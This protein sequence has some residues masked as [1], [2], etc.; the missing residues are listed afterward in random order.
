[1]WLLYLCRL[2]AMRWSVEEYFKLHSTEYKKPLK[3]SHW[4][5][6]KRLKS[7]FEWP[8]AA[9]LS[10]ESDMEVTAGKTLKHLTK[11]MDRLRGIGRGYDEGMESRTVMVPANGMLFKLRQELQ[12]DGALV[13]GLLFLAYLDIGGEHIFYILD[14]YVLRTFFI[15]TVHFPFT[16]K[17]FCAFRKG[18]RHFDWLA[19]LREHIEVEEI[20]RKQI[21]SERGEDEGS[22]A[23]GGL[24]EECKR[25][26]TCV[27]KKMAQSVGWRPGRPGRWFP[28][29]PGGGGLVDIG[30]MR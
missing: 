13:F 15:F 2:L 27:C 6:L 5:A 25:E 22:E 4:D 24:M 17:Y 12:D 20:V 26:L 8:M 11:L 19:N 10:L 21:L 18:S 9:S 29:Q 30:N 16:N 1:M 7:L 14:F 23:W 28:P 3:I